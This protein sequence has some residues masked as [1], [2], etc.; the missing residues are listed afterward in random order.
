MLPIERNELPNGWHHGQ[1]CI[2]NTF[3]AS[4]LSS[5]HL[6][7]FGIN[8]ADLI[9]RVGVII[10]EGQAVGEARQ[11]GVNPHLVVSEVEKALRSLYIQAQQRQHRHEKSFE[12][13]CHRLA[14]SVVFSC[15]SLIYN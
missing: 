9:D 10:G 3:V 13:A 6:R 8:D 1:G 4:D 15:E 5:R 7:E 2:G 12:T 14:L 11:H